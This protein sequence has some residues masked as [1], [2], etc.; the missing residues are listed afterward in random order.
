METSHLHANYNSYESRQKAHPQAG[1]LEV[2]Q[3]PVSFLFK[4]MMIPDVNSFENHDFSRFI[5]K[6]VSRNRDPFVGG[7]GL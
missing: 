1:L 7:S 6:M 5:L 2:C 4:V 3:G